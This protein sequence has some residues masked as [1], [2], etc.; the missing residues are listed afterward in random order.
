[1]RELDPKTALVPVQSTALTKV[2]AES[3]VAR[4]RTDLRIKEEAEE[5]L[6]RG[7][8][9][10]DQG[11]YE[12]AFECFE[13]GIRL[14][15]NHTELQHMLG[16]MY[17][18][19]LGVQ[20]DYAQAVAWF[21]KSADQGDVGAQIRL[22]GIYEAGKLVPQDYAQAAYWYRKAAEHGLADA[23]GSLAFAY[24]C[25]R[26]V[27]KDDSQAAYWYRKAADQGDAFWQFMLAVMYQEGRGVPYDPEQAVFWFRKSAEQDDAGAQIM[28]GGIYEEGKLVP[29][30]Y[31]QAAY[32]YLKV[33]NDNYNND[34]Q[35][36]LGR[37]YENGV[38]DLEQA[39]HWYRKAADNGYDPAKAALATL[40]SV[41]VPE[42]SNLM[43]TSESERKY[44]ELSRE[45]GAA[46]AARTVRKPHGTE[47]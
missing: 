43:P 23:Q 36:L 13:G 16:V 34:V 2:G 32:W 47:H 6:K 4:G 29:Q 24:E 35:F 26:G 11:S 15:P 20:Q 46:S 12:E 40:R 41:K 38:G 3:L 45:P 44:P 18:N 21:R 19:G 22:G 31:A 28:L 14:D 10:R 30:D 33:A 39:I 7:V 9:L 17:A 37:I 42:P 5:W 1:M 8:E 25:G 27:P